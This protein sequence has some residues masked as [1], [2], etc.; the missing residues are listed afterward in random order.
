MPASKRQHSGAPAS[1]ATAEAATMT[2]ATVNV[3]QPTH[4]MA[5]ALDTCSY[6]LESLS[7]AF[8]PKRVLLRRT[9]FLDL[10]K[11]RYVSIGYYP[12][13]NFE[14]LV[15][16]GGP[17]VAP[18]LLAEHQVRFVGEHLHQLCAE[19]CNDRP[20]VRTNDDFKLTT[21]TRSYR[22]ARLSLGSNGITYRLQDLQY[23]SRIFFMIQNQQLYY[24]QAQSDVM[25]YA[26][27]TTA[28][29]EFVLPPVNA[30]TN[31]LYPR[32]FE[33]LKALM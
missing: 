29:T 5:P 8:D 25:N 21:A 13:H 6:L 32:L 27:L 22:T 31:I 14:V 28:T 4:V 20:Y 23:L 11:T 9:F 2:D 30:S 10:E 18:I 3:R 15:E 26:V 1:R 12:A 24:I 33:E 7:P 17:R 16:L 19:M